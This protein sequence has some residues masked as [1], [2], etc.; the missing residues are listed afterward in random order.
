MTR[1]TPFRL[2]SLA[3]V[4]CAASPAAIAAMLTVTVTTT[5]GRPIVGAMV[6]AFNEPGNRKE[7]VFTGA[8]GR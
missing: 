6:T 5:D 8:D 7:T 4:L 1:A 3:L 2:A